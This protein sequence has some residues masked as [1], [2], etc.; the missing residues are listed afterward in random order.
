[1]RNSKA[2]LITSYLHLAKTSR[3]SK[4]DREERQGVREGP[5]LFY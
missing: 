3:E 4:K 5:N 1:M 2:V